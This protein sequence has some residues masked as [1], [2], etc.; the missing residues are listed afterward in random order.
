MSPFSSK[1]KPPAAMPQPLPRADGGTQGPLM[2]LLALNLILLA[3]FIM[4]N[5]VVPSADSDVRDGMTRG[6]GVAEDPTANMTLSDNAGIR[7]QVQDDM[8][9]LVA[10]HLRLLSPDLATNATGVQLTLPQAKLFAPGADALTQDGLA[11]LENLRTLLAGPGAA[12][13][14]TFLVVGNPADIPLLARRVVAV[15]QVVGGDTMRRVAVGYAVGRETGSGRA[16]LVLKAPLT[17]I[18]GRDAELMERGL[19]GAGGTL[20][21]LGRGDMGDVTGDGDRVE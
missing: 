5:A 7:R 13:S 6:T 2:L 14:G 17:R 9:G 4:L 20:Q 1:L 8:R 15:G 12:W 3:F 21:G 11:W 18:A 19:T 10:N 16:V